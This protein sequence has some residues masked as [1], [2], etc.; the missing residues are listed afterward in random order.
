MIY[1]DPHYNKHCYKVSKQMWAW[2]FNNFNNFNPMNGEVRPFVNFT[3]YD[4]FGAHV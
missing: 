4:D 2:C 1:Y 3:F